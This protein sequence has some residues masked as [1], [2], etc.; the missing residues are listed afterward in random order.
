MSAQPLKT[1]ESAAG[2]K[3]DWLLAF[4]S[5]ANQASKNPPKLTLTLDSATL[6]SFEQRLN[7]PEQLRRITQ[8]AHKQTR[9]SNVDWQDAL[10]TA[11]LKIIKS[12]RSGKFTYGTAIDFDRW[13]VTVAK[14]AI[15][16]LVRSSKRHHSQSIDRLSPD[17]LAIIDTLI[18]TADN[19][20]EL[21]SADLVWQIKEAV[22]NLDRLY[23]Q[24][25]YYRLWLGKVNEE[26]QSVIAQ[27]LGVTQS[28]ISKRWKELVAHLALKL[29]D[30]FPDGF[31][32]VSS[33]TRVRSRQQW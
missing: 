16:D 3:S 30:S 18:D 11:H 23:P 5:G 24:R 9:G 13:A 2:T 25:N 20:T 14:F 15:I 28:T 1:F 29:T 33:S 6:I 10:Q 27:E 22:L 8:V 31:I 17:N 32:T 19:L 7:N 21:E 26:T 12:L 4:T